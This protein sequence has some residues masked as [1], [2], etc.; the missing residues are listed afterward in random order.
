[1][2]T[3]SAIYALAVAVLMGTMAVAAMADDQGMNEY[4]YGAADS[5]FSA[6]SEYGVDQQAAG[7]IREPVETGSL[8]DASVKHEDGGWLNMDV[9]EQNESPDLRG[10]PNIQSGE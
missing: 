10:L 9:T 3:K 1:M 8:P 4:G 2:T 6:Q 7:E 5:S